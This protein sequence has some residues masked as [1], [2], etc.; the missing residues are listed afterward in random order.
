MNVFGIDALRPGEHFIDACGVRLRA[1]VDVPPGSDE[2]GLGAPVLVL[3]GFT[4]SAESMESV[5]A[6]LCAD[7][8]V[9]RLE[10]IGHGGSDSPVERE[11]YA[12]E[13]CAEQIVEVVR[14]LRIE[15]PHL[16]GYSMGGRA[17]IAA[18]LLHPKSFASLILIGATAGIADAVAR[19]SRIEADRILADRIESMP[20]AEFVDDWMALPIFASQK[21]LGDEALAR[22]RA[23]RM[24]NQPVG[25]ANSLRGMGAGAQAPLFDR[26][27]R[28]SRP[29]LLVAGE[30]DEKFTEIAASLCASFPNARREIV[31]G[32]GHA[33][34]LE[35]PAKFGELTRDFLAASSLSL[36]SALRRSD[37][38]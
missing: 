20:L 37:R 36:S 33:V 27:E 4:G 9:I 18:A 26:L 1:V 19:S 34:H 28:F 13:A 15:P 2:G 6:S 12:M 23:Q 10:L 31:S 22:A 29:V 3:H 14:Q 25:L 17:A 24:R 11:C 8:P 38:V 30:E 21:R 35:A 7:H 32:S 5:S 16:L